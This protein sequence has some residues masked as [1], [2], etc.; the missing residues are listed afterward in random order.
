M[1]PSARAAAA[2]AILIASLHGAEVM[3]CGY[4]DPSQVN[5]GVLNWVYPDSLQVGTAIW[6]AQLEKLLPES[7]PLAN[8]ASL[9]G[10]HTAVQLLTELGDRLDRDGMAAQPRFV[11]LFLD[12]MLWTRFAAT[13]NGL[14]R[15]VPHITGPFSDDAV[16]ITD[17][18]VV[19]ALLD[20]RI[21]LAQ[22]KRL[23]LYRIYPTQGAA[24]DLEEQLGKI[25]P[26]NPRATA[27]GLQ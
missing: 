23:G 13:E 11:L 27:A 12:S 6:Q 2:T 8:R 19:R 14:V 18:P 9:L 22:A 5:R 24:R 17:E 10:Y 20:G 26:G 7:R 4:H 16:L 15:A 21:P 3:A 25:S 1:K